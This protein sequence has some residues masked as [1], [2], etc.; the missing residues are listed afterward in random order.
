MKTVSRNTKRY[1][2]IFMDWF[3]QQIAVLP[4]P[5]TKLTV[6]FGLLNGFRLQLIFRVWQNTCC[7]QPQSIFVYYLHWINICD[8]HMEWGSSD[9]PGSGGTP[10]AFCGIV[11]VLFSGGCSDSV[12]HA[13]DR[14]TPVKGAVYYRRSVTHPVNNN[15]INIQW[16]HVNNN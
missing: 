9:C 16:Q 2:K 15:N 6:D 11:V 8:L 12:Y 1:N 4:N 5:L 10:S 13:G 7:P 3:L 14:R